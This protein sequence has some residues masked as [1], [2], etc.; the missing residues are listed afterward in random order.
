MKT[1][2]SGIS[3]L[4]G[5]LHITFLG[6]SV[7]SDWTDGAGLHHFDSF[8]LFFFVHSPHTVLSAAWGCIYPFAMKDSFFF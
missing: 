3:R 2:V 8:S 7:H 6:N 1:G 5:A 4:P